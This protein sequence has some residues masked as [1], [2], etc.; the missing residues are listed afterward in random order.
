MYAFLK[1]KIPQC[2]RGINL[3]SP[4]SFIAFLWLFEA[5]LPSSGSFHLPHLTYTCTVSHN[6]MKRKSSTLFTQQGGCSRDCIHLIISLKFSR[7]S[8]CAFLSSLPFFSI[9][10]EGEWGL[11][12][13]SAGPQGS[14][15]IPNMAVFVCVWQETGSVESFEGFSHSSMEATEQRVQIPDLAFFLR[16]LSILASWLA[17]LLFS[18]HTWTFIYKHIWHGINQISLL[19]EVRSRV[20]V[21][22]LGGMWVCVCY[23]W[24]FLT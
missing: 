8:S 15:L 5:I 21:C 7:G 19:W 23:Y 14:L 22:V 11:P 16:T 20:I 3:K 10:H 4:H 13:H 9:K 1:Q 24:L 18:C 17:V 2:C 6:A 12:L